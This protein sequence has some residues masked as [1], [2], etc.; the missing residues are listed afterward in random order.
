M[1]RTFIQVT[2]VSLALIS[3]FFLLKGSLGLSV[4]DIA[5]LSK[6]RWDYSPPVVKNLSKQQADTKIGLFLILA[7]FVLQMI[8]LMWPMRIGDF[9]VSKLGVVVAVLVAIL[10]LLSG[11]YA[12]KHLTRKTEANVMT[13][14][15]QEVEADRR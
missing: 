12:S 14:L 4:S 13:R 2:S 6:S 9:G 1:L 3:S 15:K 8:N 5:E 10:I 11:L 7:S